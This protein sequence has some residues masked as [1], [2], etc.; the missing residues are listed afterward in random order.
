MT[1]GGCIL[2]NIILMGHG[3]LGITMKKSAEMI[4]G[5]QKAVKTIPFYEGEGIETLEEKI[6]KANNNKENDLLIV[7]DLYGGTPF[8]SACSY[9]LKHKDQNII[10]LSGMS[11]PMVIQILL[12]NNSKSIIDVIND[13]EK[14][15]QLYIKTYMWKVEKTLN[16]SE[17]DDL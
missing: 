14:D 10:I 3:E 8:N 16:N 12:G 9:C 7:C 11:L 6:E 13:I 5:K 17:G 4:V 15:K 2:F 1:K